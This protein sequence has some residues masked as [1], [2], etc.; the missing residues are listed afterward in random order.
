MDECS[1]EK[2]NELLQSY[3]FQYQRNN[4]DH[5]NNYYYYNNFDRF[6]SSG[7]YSAPPPSHLLFSNGRYY[8][9]CRRAL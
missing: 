4:N 8:S 6:I 2:C 5:N 3:D 1:D 9:L 7:L